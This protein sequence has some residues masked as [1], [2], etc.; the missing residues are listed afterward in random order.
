MNG[1]VLTNDLLTSV[2]LTQT[3]MYIA[4]PHEPKCD[5]VSANVLVDKMDLQ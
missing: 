3:Y 2:W 1:H 4:L 5:Y